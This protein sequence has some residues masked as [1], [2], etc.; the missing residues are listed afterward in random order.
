[1]KIRAI[2]RRPDFHAGL[3]FW[4]LLAA[5]ALATLQGVHGGFAI[6]D[7]PN[8]DGLANVSA[9]PGLDSFLAFVLNGFSSPLGRPLALA[10]FAL[11]HHDWP[12]HAEAFI[13]VN[14]MLHLVN[15]CLVYWCLL[16]ITALVP[17]WH[18]P[19]HELVPL[20]ATAFWLFASPQAGA[21][22]YVV[23]R[24]TVLSATFVLAGLLMYL[25]GRRAE[26]AGRVRHGLFF[27]AAGVAAGA[28]IGFLAK[29]TAA[30]FPLL[31]LCLEFTLLRAL[32]R[33]RAW[34]AATVLLLWLPS[35][36]VIAKLA[37]YVP[38][39][40]P[41]GLRNFT[42][43]ER[44][45]T[46]PRIL[47]MYLG[48]ALVPPL[49]GLRLYYDDLEVSR[50]LLSPPTTALCLV[51]WTALVTLAWRWRRLAPPFTFAVAWYLGAHLLESTVIP[52]ELAFDHRNYVALLGPA[53]ALAW[54]G[55]RM[56]ALPV[57]SR[58]RPLLAGASV[59]YGL[60]IGFAFFQ[61][62]AFWSK[63]WELANFWAQRQPESRRAQLV[64]P[65]F[66]WRLGQPD[67][68]IAS[69]ERALARWPGDVAFFLSMMETSC[70]FRHLPKPDFRR[71]PAIMARWDSTFPATIGFLDS[72]VGYA[73]KGQC[74]RYSPAELW[75]VVEMVYEQPRLA[76]QMQNRYLLES[77]IAE[78]AGDRALARQLL[79]QAM[80]MEPTPAPVMFHNAIAWA[81][82]AGDVAAA[83]DY[84]QRYEESQRRY[85]LRTLASRRDRARLREAVDQ[86]SPATPSAPQACTGASC[87][88]S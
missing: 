9:A 41:A 76:T 39:E 87:Q 77:R 1:M 71:L 25:Q 42:Q 5:A 64:V 43:G 29:E 70:A 62:A 32:P 85:S 88:N 58:V 79:D 53:F 45:L 12:G 49:Y 51:F 24:M 15:G 67:E 2:L 14:V 3:L 17:A 8:L 72:L 33:S 69:D 63:P 4:G 44:L 21:V 47:L 10:T 36:L 66:Y 31:V 37:T 57:L 74:S 48:K 46:E 55:R 80:G 68:A 78:L 54:Y 59:A 83:R 27:M 84:L 52:L 40:I 81:L 60:F 20:A 18:G 35:A 19:A 82:A 11:Q 7:F 28:G 38:H 6:D 13:Y 50:S 16:R 22:L 23:Q 86:F 56:L 26:L 34:R 61:T 75:A 65:K 30:L 73:E